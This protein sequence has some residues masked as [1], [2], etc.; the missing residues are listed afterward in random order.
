MRSVPKSVDIAA[1]IATLPPGAT[2]RGFFFRDVLD[3]GA[4]TSLGADVLERA[5]LPQKKY[6]PFL[7]YPYADYLR[8]LD[9]VA[10]AWF[11]DQTQ[12]EA[13]RRYAWS[14]YDVFLD[15]QVGAAIFGMLSKD[16]ESVLRNATRGYSVA[17]NF[18]KVTVRPVS[19]NYVLMSYVGTPVLIETVQ[20]GVVEGALK[21]CGVTP[22]IDVQMKDKLGDAELHVR[23]T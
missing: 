14:T 1:H 2:L 13:L 19:R 10:R 22:D 17:I 9:V 7:A 4:R 18:G 3:R 5:G 6:Q 16:V 21:H 11:P 8:I 23:W 15:T 20:V 12:G